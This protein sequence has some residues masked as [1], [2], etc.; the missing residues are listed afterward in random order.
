LYKRHWSVLLLSVIW[1]KNGRSYVTLLSSKKYYWLLPQKY[2]L[3][4]LKIL[5][6]LSILSMGKHITLLDRSSPLLS[7]KSTT[8][9]IKKIFR[10]NV[11]LFSISLSNK[12][13]TSY[14]EKSLHNMSPLY[15]ENILLSSSE[16]KFLDRLSSLLSIKKCYYLLKIL[17]YHSKIPCTE[18]LSRYFCLLNS[19]NILLPSSPTT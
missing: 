1:T 12:S 11:G 9:Y 19:G 2:L 13:I 7:D 16:D 10:K 14:F 5:N 8:S 18:K 4:V 17:F 3:L 15:S 6:D